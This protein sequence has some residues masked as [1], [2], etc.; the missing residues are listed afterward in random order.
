MIAEDKSMLES[1]VN[2]EEIF[3]AGLTEHTKAVYNAKDFMK[4][5]FE[6]LDPT[7]HSTSISIVHFF[8][9]LIDLKVN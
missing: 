1:L 8:S 5:F 7:D 4:K 6:F 9:H 2:F 3:L